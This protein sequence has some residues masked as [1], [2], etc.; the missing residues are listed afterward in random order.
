MSSVG[1]IIRLYP[2]C[3]DTSFGTAKICNRIVSRNGIQGTEF[4]VEIPAKPYA[5]AGLRCPHCGKK[6]TGYDH[7][8][9]L[10]HKW[11]HLDMGSIPVYFTYVPR[12]GYC[13]ACDK[14]VTENLPWADH[15]SS[16][17]TDFAFEVANAAKEATKVAVA[18]QFRIS[19]RSVGTCISLTLNKIE[20]DRS[21][22]LKNL[23]RICVDEICYS[24]EKCLT[25]VVNMDTNE[26]IWLHE[27]RGDTVFAEFFESLSE[28]TRAGITIVAGDGAK[29]ID[30][31]TQKYC[32][33]AHRC[34]DNF[35]L[36]GWVEDAMNEVRK[37]STEKAKRDLERITLECK[38]E[39]K[40]AREAEEQKEKQIEAARK[41]L[42][43]MP[44]RGRPSARRKE[45]EA[46]IEEAEKE[47]E[48]INTGEPNDKEIQP[49][50]VSHTEEE[51]EKFRA[52]YEAMPRHG[53]PSARKLE[54]MAVLGIPTSGSSKGSSPL[55]N[56]EQQ[57]T[58]DS[59]RKKVTMLSRAMYAMYHNPENTTATQQATLDYLKASSPETYEAYRLK[60]Q[61]RAI[62]RMKDVPMASAALKLWV[63]DAR[64]TQLEQMV[65]LA[66][67][68]E[69]HTENLLNSIRYGANSARSESTN[70]RIRLLLKMGRGFRNTGNLF[71]MVYFI[72]SNLT[73]PRFNQF[74][75]NAEQKNAQRQ[76]RSAWKKAQRSRGSAVIA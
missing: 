10:P 75:P 67:K 19:W 32:P 38:Q 4:Y 70:T 26:V 48:Q 35:H 53:R 6:M 9:N 28:E 29:W 39:A 62:T 66:D 58:I 65:T 60:E 63:A 55:L 13:S 18:R 16:F 34:I 72:C 1:N 36:I 68:I 22:R 45:L 12:R 33:N 76:K 49:V 47:T 5:K 64:A 56:P 73:V 14:I 54:L 52:E 46:M 31:Q 69:R 25:V 40:E 71:D 23:K 21:S 43:N 59:A 57:T 37:A 3:K 11:R 51:M 41:E 44:H 15:G 7:G 42:E 50:S 2:N 30:R 8:N 20:P 17:T 24:V 61:M 27:D 74:E